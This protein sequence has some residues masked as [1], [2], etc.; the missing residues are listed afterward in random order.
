MAA[1]LVG[2]RAVLL[3]ALA[4]AC[5]GPW[6]SRRDH[7]VLPPLVLDPDAPLPVAG[8]CTWPGRVA[9]AD[10]IPA[11]LAPQLE[12]LE[13]LELRG[14]LRLST[15]ETVRPTAWSRDGTWLAIGESRGVFVWEAATGAL[16]AVIPVPRVGAVALSGDGEQVAFHAW[17]DGA[18]SLFV[19]P[20]AAPRRLRRFDVPKSETQLRFSTDGTRVLTTH[21]VLDLAS[22]R[23]AVAKAT[24]F[25]SR[26]LPDGVRLVDLPI[27]LSNHAVELREVVTGRVLRSFPADPG[28]RWS[29][30]DDGSHLAIAGKAGLDVYALDSG[31]R[32]RHFPKLAVPAPSDYHR[33]ILLSPDGSRVLISWTRE[34]DFLRPDTEMWDV[35]SGRRLWQ[36]HLGDSWRFSDDGRYLVSAYSSATILRA[37]DGTSI[38][39]KHVS[40]GLSPNSRWL[41]RKRT[42]QGSG[43]PSWPELASVDPDVADLGTARAGLVIARSHDGKHTASLGAGGELQLE[44]DDG[45]IAL[46]ITMSLSDTPRMSDA[47][48]F[49]ADGRFLL[50]AHRS[51]RTAYAWR[52]TD[53][54]AVRAVKGSGSIVKLVADTGRVIFS[55]DT[56]E[57]GVPERRVFDLL[58]G[59]E[60]PYP[61]PTEPVLDPL[62]FGRHTAATHDGRQLYLTSP[63]AIDLVDLDHPDRTAVLHPAAVILAIS[64]D[65]RLVA[66]ATGRRVHVRTRVDWRAQI[67][68]LHD[69]RVTA[70]AFSVDGK[71]LASADDGGLVTVTRILD[72]K[73]LARLRVPYDRVQHLWLSPDGTELAVDTTRGLRVRA[74]LIPPAP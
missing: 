32:V 64:P 61:A 16:R 9:S 27:S 24:P 50:V 15:A 8:E 10:A 2:M 3:L 71:H 13:V 26:I 4:T 49:S 46:G 40:V 55:H 70:L 65:D 6:S 14:D 1:M 48:T 43:G 38:T 51:A 29:V 58:A 66:T 23:R 63:S 68:V 47:A 21:T 69:Q 35:Q 57:R 56:M 25:N 11:E 19:G 30:S 22:G 72:G 33:D 37:A 52:T 17:E 44:A 31:R 41:L 7:D 42:S 36:A 45:C 18:P 73:P 28:A 34:H 59:Q 20:V 54:A 12:G 39:L 60:V 53:A 5:S 67:D 74:R 62:S